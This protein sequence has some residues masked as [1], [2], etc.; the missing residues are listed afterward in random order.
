M[1]LKKLRDL[2]E[3]PVLIFGAAGIITAALDIKIRGF[4]PVVWFLISF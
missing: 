4:S 2:L 1:S 3:M